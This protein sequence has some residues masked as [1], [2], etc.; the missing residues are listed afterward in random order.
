MPN[1]DMDNV[2]QGSLV[3]KVLGRFRDD[4]EAGDILSSMSLENL[5]LSMADGDLIGGS[6][7]VSVEAIDSGQVAHRLCEIGND[8]TFFDLCPD[9]NADIG[10]EMG[11][12]GFALPAVSCGR[13]CPRVASGRKKV[14][15]LSEDEA[16]ELGADFLKDPIVIMP[17]EDLV[18]RVQEERSSEDS[19]GLMP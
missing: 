11:S 12:R 5:G 7:L 9:E 3:V 14:S 10:Q 1:E 2:L 13:R 15:R 18:E 4:A 19:P 17:G 6:A 8:G 16:Q